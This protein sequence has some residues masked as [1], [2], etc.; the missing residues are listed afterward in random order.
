MAMK[1][2]SPAVTASR[3]K[4]A[5]RKPASDL[6]A[7]VKG[8]RNYDRFLL[9]C[10]VLPEG[11]AIGSLLAMD[12]LLRRLGKKTWVIAHDSFPERLPCLSNSRWTR[13]QDLG[14]RIPE[15]DAIVL[16][17]C[18]TLERI[19]DVR[20][21]VRS[22]TAIFN[23]DHHVSNS[24]Y[25]HYNYVRP[26]AAATAE[27]VYDVFKELKLKVNREEAKNLYIALATDTG[28]FK[29][30][31]TTAQSHLLAA[32]LIGTGIDIEKINNQLH[33]TYSLKMMNL[34][35]RL[36]KRIRTAAGGAIAWAD[37][38]REDL[39]QSGASYEDTEGFIDFLRYLK[40]VKISFFLSELE[41]GKTVRVSFRASGPYDVNKIAT[42]FNGG[43]HKKAAGC[44]MRTSLKDAEE[45]I[46]KYIRGKFNF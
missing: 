37:M 22:G 27:V 41:E 43:G 18:P 26:E 8:L 13:L 16:T 21:L 28:S 32:E 3:A 10:H 45:K 11:D 25:G 35:G 34:Y 20:N 6:K 24:F 31:N 17:D 7:L 9:T 38:Q 14:S 39:R 36:F 15:F 4:P 23:I 1:K 19:G 2:N 44:L 12:S 40:N 5:A 42:H 33:G 46:V 29:Y 30:S